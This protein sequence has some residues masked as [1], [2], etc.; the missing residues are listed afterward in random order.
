MQR[1]ERHRALI[2]LVDRQGDVTLE[3]VCRAFDVSPATARRDFSD[4]AARGAAEKVWGGIKRKSAEPKNPAGG[5]IVPS[6]L[7]ETLHSAEKTRIARAA[8]ALVRDGDV[9]IIDGGTTTLGMAAEMANRRVR[10]LTNSLLIALQIDR[11]R[12]AREG[13]DVFLTGGQIYPGS[14][15][16]VGPQ[17]VENIDSCHARWAFLSA[18]GLDGEGTTNTNQMVVE[19]ER[20]MIRRA[21]QSVVL[22]DSS[23]WGRR[24]MVRA[25]RWSEIAMLI[26]DAV[27]PHPLPAGLSVRVAA[28]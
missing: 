26:T 18:G 13:A 7:R 24:D 27:P 28:G 9:L 6:D 22:A 20:A 16:L 17:T 8:C 2:T 19:C 12:T 3:E 4:I 15:L 14:G 25:S 5:D 10:I 23:K 21:E 1:L 11:L